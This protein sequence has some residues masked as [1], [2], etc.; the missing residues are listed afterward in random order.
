MQSAKE[1]GASKYPAK[2]ERQTLLKSWICVRSWIKDTQHVCM[3]LA[4]NFNDMYSSLRYTT[5]SI[6]C[7]R[8]FC[9]KFED[10]PDAFKPFLLSLSS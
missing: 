7:S 4:K 2:T 8:Q 6:Q 5:Q 10:N 1:I 3:N 9:S